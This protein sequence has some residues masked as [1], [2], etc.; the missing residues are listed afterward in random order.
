MEAIL[1]RLSRRAR[2]LVP[3]PIRELLP[4]FSLPGVISWGGG[5]PHPDTF[6]LR[7][8]ALSF[9]GGAGASW[10]PE[11]LARACQY[12]PTQAHPAL[13]RELVRWHLFKDGVSLGE[14]HLLVV[15]GSQEGIFMAAFLFLDEGDWM[16]AAEPLYPGVSVAV[17]P[18]CATIRTVGV[19]S[20]G[21][22]T[23][24]LEDLLRAR[25]AAGDAPPKLV[26]DVPCGHNPSGATLSLERRRHLLRLAVEYDFLIL[27]D[28][29]YQ[30]IQLEQ[31]ERL[32]TLQSLEGQPCRV[33]RLDSFS[34][35]FCPGMR[36]CYVSAHPRLIRLFALLKQCMHLHT[37]MTAQ[38]VMASFLRRCGP[39]G[40]MNSILRHCASYRANRDRMVEAARRCLPHE[41]EFWVPRQGLFIWFILP[42]G[43][44]SSRML[45][46]DARDVGLVFVPGSVFSVQRPLDHCVRASF[47]MVSPQEI[48]EGMRRFAVMI[49]R[50]RARCGGW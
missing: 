16:V 2:L 30:L 13:A 26:Y 23:D 14:E 1:Q 34:K 22:R 48:D 15:N 33:I 45:E 47:S 49:E 28:D 18:F 21:M 9:D 5:Y 35:V 37:S 12:G 29:P 44:H 6:G 27:E 40:F 11:E 7:G 43:F 17:R 3:A 8:V 38:E 41:V 39:E 20:D 42:L 24:E 46:R 36:L 10:G 32:P 25:R 19:D 4:L 31:G 50:E